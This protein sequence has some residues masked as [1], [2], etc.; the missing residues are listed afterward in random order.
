MFASI[1]TNALSGAAAGSALGPLGTAVGGLL[2]GLGGMFGSRNSQKAARAQAEAAA[3]AARAQAVAR[4]QAIGGLQTS[5]DQSL[6]YLQPYEAR[7]GAAQGLLADYLGYGSG[8]D[9]RRQEL[10][11]GF[12]ADPVYRAAMQ[13]GVGAVTGSAAAQGLRNSGAAAKA[14]MGYG[15]QYA[16]NYLQDYLTR[17]GGQGALGQQAAA[18]MGQLGQGY[19]TSIANLTAGIGDSNAAGIIGAANAQVGNLQNQTSLMM[20][21]LGGTFGG[22]RANPGQISAAGNAVRGGINDL[23]GWQQGLGSWA[24]TVLPR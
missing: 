8:G 14:L 15:Q 3:A 7:G 1:A 21:G 17:L 4:Q 2:G 10:L 9:A 16:G 5:R 20:H 19:D 13:Q 22:M 6:G 11:S 12:F 24:P 18:Q 23:F